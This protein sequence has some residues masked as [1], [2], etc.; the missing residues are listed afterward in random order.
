MED[1]KIEETK[2]KIDSILKLI[3]ENKGAA[4]WTSHPFSNAM[5]GD[6]WDCTDFEIAEFL[7]KL[8]NG[9]EL[10]SLIISNIRWDT[11]G[12]REGDNLYPAIL[13][14]TKI[15]KNRYYLELKSF[16][17]CKEYIINVI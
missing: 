1:L 12:N 16:S 8:K 13:E 17:E 6:E 10:A 5:V 7:M 15:P 14:A 2:M 9:E 11:P 4:N 3:E